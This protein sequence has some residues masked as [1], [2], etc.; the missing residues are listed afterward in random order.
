MK[1]K[2]IAVT[3]FFALNVVAEES[4]FD[5]GKKVF[6]SNCVTCHGQQGDGRGP[7]SV[8][9]SGAKPRDFTTGKFKY[10]STDD[11]IFKTITNGVPGTAMPPWNS[12]SVLERKAVISYLKKFSAKN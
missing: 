3:L 5:L 10:G 11:E 9:I 2:L 8:A 6:E 4:H 1:L 12:L 7:A